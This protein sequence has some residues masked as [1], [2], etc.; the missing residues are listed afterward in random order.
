MLRQHTQVITTHTTT[1]MFSITTH[2]R[3]YHRISSCQGAVYTVIGKRPR[4]VH[5]RRRPT[6]TPLCAS[7]ATP[8]GCAF[9]PQPITRCH[10]AT[11]LRLLMLITTVSVG[12][13]ATFLHIS[14]F[15]AEVS[16]TAH[17]ASVCTA[18]GSKLVSILLILVR[19]VTF[20]CIPC[21]VTIQR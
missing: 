3:Q 7:A 8:L 9:V 17:K 20:A 11:S 4:T 12:G 15:S 13:I 1:C 19:I 16:R 6:Y 5:V 2:H 18:V 21:S 14:Y 10:L